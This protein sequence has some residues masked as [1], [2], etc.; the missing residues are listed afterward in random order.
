M[1][2]LV[3]H[4]AVF[5]PI[6]LEYDRPIVRVGSSEDNDLVLRHPSIEP[7]HCWLVFRGEKLLC[8]PPTRTLPSIADLPHLT[9]SELGVGDSILIGDLRFRL[10]HSSKTVAVPQAGLPGALAD[11]ATQETGE[12]ASQPRH[13]CAH[14]RAWI[15]DAEVK[16]VGLVGHAKRSLCPKCSRPLE[17]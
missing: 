11:A 9:G 14:C 7:Y 8:L 4:T 17:P 2:K 10:E 12:E 6:D 15:H 16:R 5:G 13:Y 3:Y 1:L